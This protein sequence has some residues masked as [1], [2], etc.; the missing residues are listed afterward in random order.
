MLP[1]MEAHKTLNA[2]HTGFYLEIFEIIV[3]S[4]SAVKRETIYMDIIVLCP[5]LTVEVLFLV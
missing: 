4:N 1:T 2:F 5:S 3:A